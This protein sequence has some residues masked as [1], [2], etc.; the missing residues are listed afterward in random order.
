MNINSVDLSWITG[1]ESVQFDILE[2][3]R[4]NR[5]SEG[6]TCEKVEAKL[7]QRI[8]SDNHVTMVSSGT[9][10]LVVAAMALGLQPGD[11][12]I[13]PTLTF[14]ATASAFKAVGV[15]PVFVDT[16]ELGRINLKSVESA[17]ENERD[18]R[19]VVGVH[20]YGLSSDS[21]A[22]SMLCKQYG[23]FFIE[24]AAQA[25]GLKPSGQNLGFYSDIATLSL[26][27][28]KNLAAGEGG[29]LV[30]KDKQLSDRIKKIKNHG[31][32]SHYDYDELGLNFRW[33]EFFAIIANYSLDHFETQQQKRIS[34]V[35]KLYDF[36][37][38]KSID[39][40]IN[41]YTENCVFHQFITLHHDREKLLVNFQSKGIAV[42]SVYPKLLSDT[43]LYK[44]TKVYRTDHHDKNIADHNI[45]WP[46]SPHLTIL[47]MDFLLETIDQCI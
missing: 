8:G 14:V 4:N 2:A 21:C 15:E 45:A 47:E 17:L 30:T 1:S 35:K 28:S 5:L 39:P 41:P 43:K 3:L 40:L 44:D 7:R 29:A 31:R 25:I 10:A 16:D 9:A 6:P 36:F 27:A 24:D 19:A 33:P 46:I 38:S 42:G 32:T 22:L 18:V 26:Y 20:L 37:K 12:I 23:V 34:N 13:V 11:K